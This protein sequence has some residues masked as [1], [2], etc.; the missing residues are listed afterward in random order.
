MGLTYTPNF[1]ERHIFIFCLLKTGSSTLTRATYYCLQE[2]DRTT[3]S[4]CRAGQARFVSMAT[5][6][7][8]SPL[9]GD[10]A[11]IGEAGM[12]SASLADDTAGLL[13][14]HFPRYYFDREEGNFFPCDINK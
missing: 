9:L 1:R 13:R 8:A 12:A 4:L 11:P 10:V 6:G 2:E 3:F 14:R 5:T 7:A